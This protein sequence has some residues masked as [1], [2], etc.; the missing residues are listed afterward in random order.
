V[1]GAEATAESLANEEVDAA[2]QKLRHMLGAV[3]LLLGY[4]SPFYQQLLCR[5]S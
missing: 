5:V 3:D 2:C 1:L 4:T